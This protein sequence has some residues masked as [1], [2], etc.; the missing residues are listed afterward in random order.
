[1]TGTTLSPEFPGQGVYLPISISW[2]ESTHSCN[3][4]VDSGA[5]GNFI[6][7]NFAL[8]I[9]VPLV[10]L[11][12]PLSVSALD[13][14]ALGDGKV[15]QATTSLRLQ[16]EAHREELS[17]HVIHSPEFPVVLGIPWLTRHNPH[18]D[19]VTGRILEWGPTCHATCLFF[20]PPA[21]PA[22][23]LDSTELS[24]VP[25][26]YRDLKEVFSKRRAASLPP[27]RHYDCA[28]DLLPGTT[29]PRGRIFSL[30]LPERKAMDDYI[31]DAL[32][33]GFIRPST[34]PAGAGFFFVS[35]KDG[36][37]RPCIDYRALNKITIRNRYPLPLMSTA[38]DL[39]QGATVFTKLD[40]RNAYHLVRIRQGDEWKTAFNTPSGHYEY[41]VMPFGLT[42][43]PAVFQALIND[44]LRDMI[45]HFVFV[46]LDDILIF[47]R[48][49]KEHHHHV[50]QVLQRLLKN[51]LYV[52][53]Q[54][55][56]FH[57]TEASFLGFILREGQLQMDP[58]KTDAV[59]KWPTPKSVKEVQQFLGFA[60][61]YRKFI[62]N[63]SS[64]AAP[65]SALTKKTK[66]PFVWTSK[67][68]EAF[69]DLKLRFSSAPVLVLPDPSQPFIV[70]VDASD[71]GVGAVLS[72]RSNGRLHPCAYLSHRL[73]PTEARYDI[74]DRELLAVKKAL[75][76]WRHWLEGAQHPFLV[77]TDHK[78]LEYLQQ[79]K[80]LNPRQ[81]RWAMFFSRFDFTLSY[82][83]GSKNT[84]PDALSRQFP[85][86]GRESE[87]STVVPVS[88][89]IAPV[90]WGVEAAI[91][92]AQHQE[93]DPG[94]GPPGLLYV[95]SPVRAKAL[96]WGHSSHLTAHP[97]SRRTLEFLRRRFW[98]P[99]MEKDVKSFVM[100]CPVCTRSKNPRQAP[101]GLLHPLCIPR[102]PWSHVSTDFITG[103][104]QSEGN[105]VI[106][107]VVDRF[108]KACRFIPLQKLP[109]ALETAKLMFHHVFRVF[110]LPQDIVSDRGPQFSSR[111]WRAFCR[112]LGATASL[113]S[114]FHPQ[115]NGQTERLNQELEAT[116][117]SLAMD[118]PSSW[119]S[120]LPWAEYAHN[121]LQSSA[122]KV[123]PFQCQFG[124]Q[125]PLF[126]EQEEDAGVPSV[127][128][129]MRRCRKTWKKV[130]KALLRTSKSNQAQANR[131]R[132]PAQHFR[133]G[134]RVWLSSKD[135]PL[136]VE[137]RKLAPRYTGPF[138]VVRRVNP[139]T[140]QLQLPRSLRINP[141]FHVSLLRPVLSSPHAPA[142]KAPPPPRFINGEPIFTVHRLLDSRRVRGG[143]QYLV[144][145]EGY[146]PEERSWV[147][148]RDIV[149]K[150]LCKEF[151]L[152]H[153][154]KPGNARRRSKRGGS[155]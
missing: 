60:N 57:V 92:R 32:A 111:V 21:L 9:N 127:H 102:R 65:I 16:S 45:N 124:F 94:G 119:S 27:H 47:S 85:S 78:N 90:C 53:A 100:A 56:E 64:V 26:E 44:V 115:S 76:E 118:N 34:S 128:H 147:A 49:L 11:E 101:Q 149:D 67:A 104:P 10:P 62:R 7:S 131:R 61:F 122:T 143:V 33:S 23:S 136:R 2:G 93:P 91:R 31:Q 73:D 125:P 117:R 25:A 79:A 139:V 22:E 99:G 114:G 5:A 42:N 113:S 152:S 148:A 12:F 130:R 142:P 8:K 68:E 58:A 88:R 96:Q 55:C 83:P 126:P 87:V 3:A 103:L 35:K 46:Y 48:T 36:G 150:T 155:C 154:D 151:H 69:Q 52:K 98:W 18:I 97:G 107:V 59:R 121:T 40:L 80:R 43:A 108:S 66:E 71:V 132:R 105:T 129:F 54:K 135:L 106:L 81:A 138:K 24:Q 123:S 141:T 30:S 134:Q 137:S 72:Q 153:P 140:Y 4:L 17:L 82:R 77:W 13:G 51:H 109:S 28:I 63:F 74:G 29:P 41:Q 84:K 37:L 50:R 110:G 1:M 116:L 86:S 20:S 112:L 75:D 14:Q 38:F 146:G 70:E 6:D 95:P 120:W 133:P 145:W 19:W 89:I 39:L 144:D 15:T